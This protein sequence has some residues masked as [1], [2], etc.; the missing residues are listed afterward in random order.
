MSWF[1]RRRDSHRDHFM[2]AAGERERFMDA[3]VYTSTQKSCVW[4]VLA[5]S[6]QQLNLTLSFKMG[7]RDPYRIYGYCIVA[8]KI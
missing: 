1:D 7:S 6:Q 4:V 5:I 2:V 3:A 8:P